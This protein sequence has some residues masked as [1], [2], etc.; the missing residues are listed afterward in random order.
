MS[1]S[2]LLAGSGNIGR[3][4]LQALLAADPS[5]D[6]SVTVI[7]PFEG[8]RE[9][10]AAMLKGARGEAA[11]RAQAVSIV[12]AVA[13]A[14]ERADL[15]I[16]ATDAA[17][18]RAVFDALSA[19][20]S[21][22]A[23]VFE[24][25]LFQTNRDLDEVR[26]SLEAD[27]PPAFVN[28]GRRGFPGYHELRD[29][30][31]GREGFRMDVAGSR[32]GLASNAVHFTDLASFLSGADLVSLDASGLLPGAEESK[33]AGYV[34]VFGTLSG[35][36]SDGGRIAVTCTPDGDAPVTIRLSADGVDAAVEEAAARATVN[37][38]T[39]PF[40]TRYVSQM[41][42]LFT[43]ILTRGTSDLTPYAVSAAQHR[44]LIAALRR[45][46]GIEGDAPCPI[47]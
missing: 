6:F 25:V 14:P 46:L 47:T 12:T 1:H 33:R 17:P 13:D 43:D 31:A 40:A 38:E 26:R 21:V 19:H 37:G 30:F 27:G 5:D 45:H 20:A 18:R 24:K 44:L 10:T 9:A 29:R 36:L 42:Y 28:C 22:G 16:I 11:R 23:W 35:R 3:R 7:E 34:E 41:P 2:I 15:A 39:R 8:A 4:H 32:Y